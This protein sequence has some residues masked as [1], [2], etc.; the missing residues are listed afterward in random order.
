MTGHDPGEDDQAQQADSR[1]LADEARRLFDRPPPPG[2]L[3]E[4]AAV[5]AAP[6]AEESSDVASLLV[7][8]VARS[9]LAIPTSTLVEVAESRP[10]HRVPHR[11]GGLL[12]GLI[13]IRGRLSPCVDVLRLLSIDVAA[14]GGEPGEG[15]R[16][17]VAE[18]ARGTGWVAFEADEVAGVHLVPVERLRGLP[19]TVERAEGHCEATFRWR[20]QT[21][22]VLDP[23]RFL[24]AME[25]FDR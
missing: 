22:G 15:R 10:I 18:G 12:R 14:T 21:V 7:F 5:L 9:W 16:V 8:R 20:E 19:S 3:E 17:V 4:W 25:A 2:Y 13:N 23:G 1:S 11:V 24:D 6:E